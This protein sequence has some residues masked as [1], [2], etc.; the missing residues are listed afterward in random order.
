MSA[1]QI[2]IALQ[3]Q[4]QHSPLL[5][6][7]W[8]IIYSAIVTLIGGIAT[9]FSS[10]FASSASLT[11][12]LAASTLTG[13]GLL[14]LAGCIEALRALELA[15][16]NTKGAQDLADLEKEVLSW[17]GV[18]PE[19]IATLKDLALHV[20]PDLL[21]T[22]QG[23]ASIPDLPKPTFPPGAAPL[24]MPPTFGSN[25]PA[26]SLSSGVQ[27]AAAPAA[28]ITPLRPVSPPT[29]APGAG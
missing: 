28:N 5:R 26:A 21:K 25:K 10:Q 17:H 18:T 16:G 20:A 19:M 6:L 3:R 7:L 27:P 14:F 9:W 29:S 15:H 24:P 12:I 4:Y 1:Q 2:W 22:A 13:A 8:F 23:G 11:P